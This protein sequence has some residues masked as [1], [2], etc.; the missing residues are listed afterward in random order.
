LESALL[1]RQAEIEL[2]ERLFVF[3]VENPMGA[4][5]VYPED[6]VT[7]RRQIEARLRESI[8]Q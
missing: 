2:I 4:H 6:E 7:K 3:E 5:Q 1:E 8:S